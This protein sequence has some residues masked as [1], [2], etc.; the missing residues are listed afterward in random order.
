MKVKSFQFLAERTVTIQAEKT[1]G[2]DANV[3]TP[4]GAIHP[5]DTQNPEP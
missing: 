5:R 3:A 2:T 4:L 1:D